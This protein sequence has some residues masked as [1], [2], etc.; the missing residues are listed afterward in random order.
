MARRNEGKARLLYNVL[1]ARGCFR[2][3][4][5]KWGRAGWWDSAEGAMYRHVIAMKRI[6]PALLRLSAGGL[7]DALCE[8]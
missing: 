6:V 3:A 1:G 7:H 8:A 4:V 2:N 5:V